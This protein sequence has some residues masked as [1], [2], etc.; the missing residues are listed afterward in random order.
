MS[1]SRPTGA[2]LLFFHTNNIFLSITSDIFP[3]VKIVLLSKLR[4]VGMNKISFFLAISSTNWRKVVGSE[5]AG[6]VSRGIFWDFEA[7]V[8]VGFESFVSGFCR[9]CLA[10]SRLAYVQVSTPLS[11]HGQHSNH[12]RIQIERR[13]LRKSKD[14]SRGRETC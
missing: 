6:R 12:Q 3:K 9:S 1:S 7:D 13:T 5:N 14:C 10:S 2:H 8:E 4:L 11:L